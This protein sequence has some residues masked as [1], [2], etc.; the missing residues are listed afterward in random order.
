MNGPLHEFRLLARV[1]ERVIN[2]IFGRHGNG[3]RKTVGVSK[4]PLVSL[5][6]AIHGLKEG[7][8]LFVIWT[9]QEGEAF[10][11]MFDN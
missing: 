2:I 4:G 7:L 6:M 11:F 5:H 8:Q 10:N 1:V 3:H 9:I